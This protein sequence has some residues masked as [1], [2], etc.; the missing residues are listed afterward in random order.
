VTPAGGGGRGGG[1]SQPKHDPAFELLLANNREWVQEQLWDDPDYFRKLAEGQKPTILLV[2]CSDSRMSI[3]RMLGTQ[4]GELFIHRNIANQAPLDDPNFQAV[5]EFSIMHLAVRHIVVAG[6]TR[7]GGAKAA[8][9][10]VEGGAVGSWLGPLKELVVAHR[11][12]LDAIPGDLER[13]NR[14]AE[15]NVEVQVKNVLRSTPYRTALGAG[16]PP[17]VHGWILDLASGLIREMDP[18]GDG[19]EPGGSPRV[20]G[21]EAHGSKDCG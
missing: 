3:N 16:D 18:P 19:W 2:G 12:E 13:Q 20:S 1:H 4:P 21:P 11:H 10:G 15:L 17:E 6:H 5:L 7:C 14:L 8:L 9:A